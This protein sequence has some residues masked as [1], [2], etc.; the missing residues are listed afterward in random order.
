MSLQS[1]KGIQS[2]QL[3]KSGFL[4]FQKPP[5]FLE[6]GERIVWPLHQSCIDRPDRS[7]IM[8]GISSMHMPCIN[9]PSIK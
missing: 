1:Q 6:Y 4:Y 3:V 8:K 9:M 5:C 7:S 2:V